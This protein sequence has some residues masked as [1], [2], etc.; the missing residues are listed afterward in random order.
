MTYEGR[1]TTNTTGWSMNGISRSRLYSTQ[2]VSLTIRDKNRCLLTLTN[3]RDAV[4]KVGDTSGGGQV[5]FT[6][7]QCD[8]LPAQPARLCPMPKQATS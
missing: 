2:P 4:G 5:I 3:S 8:L 1:S 6:T 7:Q